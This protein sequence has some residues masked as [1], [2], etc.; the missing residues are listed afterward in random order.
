[1]EQQGFWKV[2][3]QPDGTL[4]DPR[5]SRT[6][7]S[8]FYEADRPQQ[9]NLDVDKAFC[10]KGTSRISLIIIDHLKERKQICFWKK[11]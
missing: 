1:M 9:Y 6:Y 4:L 8:L 10:I 7:N 3:A 11:F 5:T 2:I